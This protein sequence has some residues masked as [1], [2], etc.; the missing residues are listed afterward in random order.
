[1]AVDLKAKTYTKA[2]G[3]C[4]VSRVKDPGS[5]KFEIGKNFLGESFV[6][7]Q[8]KF[9]LVFFNARHN[10]KNPSV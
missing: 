10:A 1:M 7:R 4:E 9:E 8:M 6:L 3:W 5:G 2:L